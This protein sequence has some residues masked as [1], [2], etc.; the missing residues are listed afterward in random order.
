MDGVILLVTPILQITLIDIVLSGDNI[1]LIALAIKNLPKREAK[2]AALTGIVSAIGFR[3]LF[4]SILT[5][6]ME[7][8]WLPIKMIGGLLLLKITWD[9][10]HTQIESHNSSDL[11]QPSFWKAVSQIIIADLSMSLDNVLAIASVAQGNILLISF[12]IA[13]NIPI[14]FLGA[15][16]VANLMEK[17]HAI[18]Y[19]A[20][21]IL[22]HTAV[23]IILEDPFI[24]KLV[25]Q[26]L[27]V[28]IPWFAA[29]A[30][31]GYITF[32]AGKEYPH[33]KNH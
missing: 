22:I 27:T 3:I 9:M 32:L 17:Y 14:I 31:V 11:P 4:A 8:E 6:I 16:F 28:Y 21:G 19:I 26:T 25:P 12:G 33:M 24:H 23:D 7:L 20:A 29:I 5:L 2:L 1:G 15:H 18:I 10:V 13:L 30:F